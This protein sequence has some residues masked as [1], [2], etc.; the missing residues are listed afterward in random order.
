MIVLVKEMGDLKATVD[1]GKEA[2][3]LY[4][5]IHRPKKETNRE[6]CVLWWEV[7]RL[8]TGRQRVKDLRGLS[9]MRD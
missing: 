9:S 4:K 7:A 3:S 1:A 8:H 2:L 5:F 6:E